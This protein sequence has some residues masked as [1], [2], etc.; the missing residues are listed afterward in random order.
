M[1]RSLLQDFSSNQLLRQA[2]LSYQTQ[3]LFGLLDDTDSTKFNWIGY[4]E[5][6]KRA[7]SLS[8]SLTELFAAHPRAFLAIGAENRLEWYLT[9]YAC[10]FSGI[11]TAPIHVG[12]DSQAV[13]Y[14]LE[15]T[16]APF[17]VTTIK[18]FDMV[19]FP[20]AS[21][22]ARR[23]TP[24]AFQFRKAF[25]FKGTF[26]VRGV[27]FMDGVI[28]DDISSYLAQNG[29][30]AVFLPKLLEEGKGKPLQLAT[31][32]AKDIVTLMF[33]SGSTGIPKGVIFDETNTRRI[34]R[35]RASIW[36]PAVSVSCPFRL[37]S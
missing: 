6:Y 10:V 5:I 21:G 13:A 33:T 7:S 28:P 16:E 15:K 34:L 17:V 26:S 11:P 31:L 18:C 30:G 23:L 25:D 32:G 12:L 37:L 36:R 27:I 19:R 8:N 14:I 4:D 20:L 24:S 2:F 29:L 35:R 22:H 3:Q 1:D 9:D